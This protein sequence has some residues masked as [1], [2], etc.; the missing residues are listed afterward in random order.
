MDIRDIYQLFKEHPLICTDTRNITKNSLFFAL[1]GDNFNGNQFASEAV[2]N[3]AA[4]SI[5]DEPEHQKTAHHILVDNVLNTLQQLASFHSKQLNIPIIGITGTNGKTTTKELTQSVLSQKY[6]CYATKGNLNNHIGVPL[7]VLEINDH[8]E[9][10]I[11]EMGANHIGEIADLCKISQPT[12]GLITNIGKAH[13]E[14]FGSFDGVKQAK[15]ELYLFLQNHDSPVFINGDNDIL[16]KLA[17]GLF[18]ITYGNSEKNQ[19]I[20]QLEKSEEHLSLSWKK[21]NY[22]GFTPV[23]STNLIG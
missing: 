23:I 12:T 20:G 17:D 9:I 22:F 3:G 15:S 5:I 6:L 11:I 2:Q 8:H 1:K 7:S 21:Y 13:L 18:Q 4:Y 10:A 14:G 19:I 16:G